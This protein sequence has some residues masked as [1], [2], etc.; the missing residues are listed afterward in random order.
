M[1]ELYVLR[2]G[3]AA[4]VGLPGVPDLERPLTSEG[5]QRIRQI[6]QGLRRLNLGLESIASS[7]AQRAWT[8]AEIVADV[9]DLTDRLEPADALLPDRNPASIRDWLGTRPEKRLMLVGHNPSLSDLVG[10]LLTGRTDLL[11]IDLRKG[12]IAALSS[13]SGSGTPMTLD[14]L[15]RPRLF[16]HLPGE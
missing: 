16:R 13:P 10:L 8:T 15:A 7:P 14:W 5:E 9:L 11:S 6:A 2:H 4:P 12:G 3:I 1:N